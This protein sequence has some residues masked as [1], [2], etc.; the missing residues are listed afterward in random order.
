[1]GAI[2]NRISPENIILDVA[3]ESKEEVLRSLVD[4]LAETEGLNDAEALYKDVLN[5]EGMGSTCLG[6]GCAV[7][8]AHSESMEKTVIAA[9]RINTPA[10]FTTP[11]NEPVS[12]VFLLAGPNGSAGLHLKLLSKLARL[13]SDAGFRDE[14]CGSDSPEDF[15]NKICRRED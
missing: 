3:A 1:M 5:R 13:L 2:C 10:D 4:R 9:A 15:Y 12:L 7:P 11:D 14:L 6:H 8:H